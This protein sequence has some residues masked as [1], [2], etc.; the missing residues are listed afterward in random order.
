MLNELRRALGFLHAVFD[1]FLADDGFRLCA[2]LAYTTLLCIVPALAV[3]LA[4]FTAFPGFDELTSSIQNFFARYLLPQAVADKVLG[5]IDEFARNAA[6]L[7]TVGVVAIGVMAVVLIHTIERAFNQIWRVRRRRPTALRILT[8]WGVITLGPLVAGVSIA[9]TSYAMS[10]WMGLTEGSRFGGAPVLV[11]V[12]WL[13]IILGLTML[14]VVVPARI[15]LWRHAFVGALAAATTFQVV[16]RGFGLWLT[17]F[18]SYT[19]VYGTLAAVPIFLIWIYVSWVVVVLGAELVALAPDYAYAHGPGGSQA[20]ASGE[21]P[22]PSAN[23]RAV[24]RGGDPD[25]RGN[26]VAVLEVVRVLVIAQASGLSLASRRVASEARLRTDLAEPILER[27]AETGWVGR[28]SGERWALT[29]NPAQITIADLYRRLELPQAGRSDAATR[30]SE[31]FLR[32]IEDAVAAVS[33]PLS[34][35]AGPSTGIPHPVLQGNEP[36]SDGTEPEPNAAELTPPRSPAAAMRPP[37][38]P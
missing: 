10:T 37:P 1:R 29:C 31:R 25:L 8:Y 7:T 33:E 15:V 21:R 17:H 13:L 22:A 3:G 28:L 26:F 30:V 34:I 24:R 9:T 35:L 16:E 18:A 4:I 19:S 23:G 12:P 38:I 11:V 5:Y 2:S 6:G 36:V 20:G 27:L 14:Y 32:R